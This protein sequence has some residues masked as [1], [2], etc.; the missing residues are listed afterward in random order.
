VLLTGPGEADT[1]A[2]VLKAVKFPLL[3]FP[4]G[5]IPRL[6]A[7]LAEADLLVGNDSGP[8]HIAI[9]F[10][11][12]VVC[13]MG[14]TSPRYT[15]S[16]WEKGRVLRVEVDCGPCQKPVCATDHRCMTRISVDAVVEAALP[17]L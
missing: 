15:D 1:R 7:V 11:K 14:P 3:E 10:G 8:R 2:A 17:F 16:P 5:G 13:V 6:K 12:P 4:G 9:A